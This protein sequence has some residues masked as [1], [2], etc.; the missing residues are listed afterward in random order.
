VKSTSQ[1][2]KYSFFALMGSV[3]I[4]HFYVKYVKKHCFDQ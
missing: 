2:K 1:C 4:L 3:F